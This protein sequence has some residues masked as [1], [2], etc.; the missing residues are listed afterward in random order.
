MQ[1]LVPLLSKAWQVLPLQKLCLRVIVRHVDRLPLA[2]LPDPLLNA[3]FRECQERFA[4]E[5]AAALR[6]FF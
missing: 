6:R 5:E 2:R 1:V 4:V 3:V